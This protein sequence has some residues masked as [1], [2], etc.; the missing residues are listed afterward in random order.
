MTI[1]DF[2]TSAPESWG[3]NDPSCQTKGPLDESVV[4]IHGTSDNATAWSEFVP[5]LKKQ[6]MCVW[7]FDYDASRCRI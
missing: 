6:G 2:E 3:I 1:G 4:L 7:A 5:V